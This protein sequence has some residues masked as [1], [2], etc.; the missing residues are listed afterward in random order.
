MATAGW[1]FF[2]GSENN[3][4]WCSVAMPSFL[5]TSEVTGVTG[6]ACSQTPSGGRSC[7]TL[8]SEMTAVVC[9]RCLWITQEVPHSA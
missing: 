4:G 5:P 7:P 2:Q 6:G 1:V 8:V 9:P 3:N